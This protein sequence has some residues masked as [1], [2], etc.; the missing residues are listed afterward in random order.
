MINVTQQKSI[1][2][3][4]LKMTKRQKQAEAEADEYLAI[5]GFGIIS[6]DSIPFESLALGLSTLSAKDLLHLH[7]YLQKLELGNGEQ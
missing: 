7:V 1:L 3:S 4:D 6:L 2:S 5:A